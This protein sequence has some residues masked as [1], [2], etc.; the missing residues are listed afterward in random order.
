[1][2]PNEKCLFEIYGC[3]A[4]SEFK[5]FVVQKLFACQKLGQ[6]K[7][8]YFGYE[9]TELFL[10][11]VS[12]YL[13]SWAR[14]AHKPNRQKALSECKWS[15]RWNDF[16]VEMSFRV[17]DNGRQGPILM[18]HRNTKSKSMCQ[19]FLSI[20]TAQ[21]NSHRYLWVIISKTFMPRVRLIR[22]E[23]V[24]AFAE[25]QTFKWQMSDKR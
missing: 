2:C 22:L 17:T 1:M 4:F 11:N 3:G 6:K 9:M 13:I 24:Q 12:H 16:M 25:G 8:T 5:S 15:L 18:R 19:Q 21:R 14:K 7:Y 23:N 10:L 20:A